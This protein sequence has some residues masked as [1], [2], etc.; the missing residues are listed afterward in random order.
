MV[1]RQNEMLIKIFTPRLKQQ[2]YRVRLVSSFFKFYIK[3]LTG[4]LMK[5]NLKY[6]GFDDIM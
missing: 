2:L 1:A 6:L 3:S 4:D 5:R